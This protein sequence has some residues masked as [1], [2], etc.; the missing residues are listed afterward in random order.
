MLPG[1]ISARNGLPFEDTWDI[2]LKVPEIFDTCELPKLI[3]CAITVIS[4]ATRESFPPDPMPLYGLPFLKRS[5]TQPSLLL[6]V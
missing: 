4:P 2:C 5:V 6:L 3:A 1:A